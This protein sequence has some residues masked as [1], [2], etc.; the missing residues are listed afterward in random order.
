MAQ[1]QVTIAEMEDKKA[2]LTTL[3][4]QFEEEISNTDQIVANL[5]NEW[6][7]DASDA[8]QESYK[9][10]SQRLMQAAEGIKA[11]ITVLEKIIE[12]YIQ[13]EARNAQIASK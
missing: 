4:S 7:G 6:E 8:F 3:L 5:K 11:Y 12:A 2:Q 13:T 9:T 10:K 1:I